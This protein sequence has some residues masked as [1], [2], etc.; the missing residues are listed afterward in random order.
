MKRFSLTALLLLLSLVLSSCALLAPL[1]NG[2]TA[3]G[4]SDPL[5]TLSS[6]S[7]A[8]EKA[9][10]RESAAT[11]TATYQDPAVTLTSTFAFTAE[12]ETVSY[13]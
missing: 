13:T 4:G 12:G 2:T 8:I 5:P 7:D 9:T 11:V 10:P 6:L 3:G 1:G